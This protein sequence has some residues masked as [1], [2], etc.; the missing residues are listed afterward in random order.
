M[1]SLRSKKKNK[2]FSVFVLLIESGTLYVIMLV[3]GFLC[4]EGFMNWS[5]PNIDHRS[6]CD[7]SGGWRPGKRRQDDG[8]HFRIFNRAICCTFFRS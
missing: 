4:G 3:R 5:Q 6:P 8:L 7:L 1:S 2:V